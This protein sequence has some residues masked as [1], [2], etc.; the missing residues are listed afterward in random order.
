M[1][2]LD[3]IFYAQ[4]LSVA[5]SREHRRG[6]YHGMFDHLFKWFGFD[7]T[8]KAVSNYTKAKQLNPKKINRRSDVQ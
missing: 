3:K 2:Y 6:K 5:D 4:V 1:L 7:H 8:S